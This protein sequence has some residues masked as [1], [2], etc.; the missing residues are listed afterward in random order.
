MGTS[1]VFGNSLRCTSSGML[2]DFVRNNFSHP[3]QSRNGPQEFEP[4]R[5]MP[6]ELLP[7]E[8]GERFAPICLG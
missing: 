4:H 5:R 2:A 7:L 3:L 1:A 6:Q 8:V